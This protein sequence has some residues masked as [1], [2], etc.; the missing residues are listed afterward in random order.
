LPLTSSID[1]KI[2][3]IDVNDNHPQFSESVYN[4]SFYENAEIGTTLIQVKATD[5]DSNHF[6]KVAYTSINGPIAKK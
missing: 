2:G 5:K 4:V 6:G 3:I 1:C